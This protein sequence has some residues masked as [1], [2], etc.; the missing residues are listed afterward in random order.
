MD[1]NTVPTQKAEH[2]ELLNKGVESFGSWIN[3]LEELNKS[4]INAKPFPNVEIDGFFKPEIA[5]LLYSVFPKVTDDHKWIVYNNP[6]E[7]KHALTDFSSLPQFKDLFNLLQTKEFVDL[8][9]KISGIE[10]LEADP[11]L[12]GAGLHQHIPGGKLDMHLDYSI[13]PV[14]GKERR[15]NLI[16]YF[17]K[18]WQNDYG[19]AI[20]LWN[21]D[22]SKCEKKLSPCFNKAILFRTSDVSYH[23]L[24]LPIKCPE[25]NSRKSIAIYYV[26]DPR[27]HL[28]NIR[29]KAQFRPLPTQPVNDKLE[30]LYRI[31]EKRII[32][33]D[34]LQT[35]YPNWETD[36]NGFW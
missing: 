29:Y 18:D 6:I 24:P 8:V 22:F 9:K 14:T 7:K 36:G 26:S 25:S 3:N 19:G 15:V 20:E 35:I 11:N 13:H 2:F 27:P 33:K 34:D 1:T 31:R 32:T 10:N 4:F 12:H 30:Q 5:E 21:E 17:T 23:G 16:I 28:D